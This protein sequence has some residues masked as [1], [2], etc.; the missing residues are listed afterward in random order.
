M[1]CHNIDWDGSV[2]TIVPEVNGIDRDDYDVDYFED[3]EWPDNQYYSPSVRARLPMDYDE[4]YLPDPFDEAVDALVEKYKSETP[5]AL[6]HYGTKRHSGRYPWGSGDNPYQHSSDFLARADA[7]KKSNFTM[8]DPDTGK[9]LTGEVAIARAFE[10]STTAFRARYAN[11][12]D[13]RRLREADI[14]QQMRRDGA[15]LREIATA[16]GYKNDSSVRVLLEDK[17]QAK[18]SKARATAEVLK[19]KLE[20]YNGEGYLEVGKGAEIYLGVSRTKLDQALTLLKDEGYEVWAG[21]VNQQTN[22]NQKT[23]TLVLCP[24]G[25]PKSAPYEYDKIHIVDDTISYDGGESFK[26]AWHYPES[27]DSKRLSI[28]YGDEGGTAKDGLV[29]IRRGVKDLSLGESNYAQ[30]RILV[31]DTHYIKG[32]AVYSNDLPDGVDV[33]FNTNKPSGTDVKDVLKSVD[34]NLKKDP[35]NPF[36]S[37]VK[38]HGGQ[39][40]YTDDDGKEKLG[41][42]N[43]TREEG[44]WDQWKD[45]LPSQFL[46]KQDIK[47]AKNQLDISIADAKAEFDDIMKVSNPVIRKNLLDAYALERDSD[48]EHLQ[49]AALP[50]QK[51]KVFLPVT[52]GLADNEVYCPSL[53]QGDRVAV[54]RFPHAGIFEIPILKV[55]NNVPQAEQMMGKTASDVI[56]ITAKTAAQLSGADFDGDAGLVIPIGGKVKIKATPYLKELEGYDPKAEYPIAVKD[57]GS[58]AK[59]PMSEKYKQKQMGVVSNLIT[60]MTVKNAKPEEVAEVTR[61]SMTVIDAVKHNLD[62]RQSA[63]DNHMDHWHETYQGSK[64]GGAS[65]ILSLAKSPARVDKRVGSPKIDPETGDLVWKTVKETYVDKKGKTQE[66]FTEVS[67]MSLVKDAHELSSGREIENVYA[68]FANAQKNLARKARLEILA[69]PHTKVNPGAR[70]EYADEVK[71]IDSKILKAKANAPREKQAQLLTASKVK[72]IKEDNPDLTKE[73]LKKLRTRT[74]TEMRNKVGARRVEA[75]LTEREW[76]AIQAGAISESKLQD[77]IRP[78]GIDRMRE[79]ATPRTNRVEMTEGKI[80][81]AK[82]MKEAGFTLAAIAERLGV[83][84]ATASKAIKS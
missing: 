27:L 51:Y 77:L 9:L 28:V 55:N 68:D 24:P 61:H 10:M 17:Q 82:A 26:P 32:M 70:A 37:L 50:R 18:R 59:K 35:N 53:K 23:N 80:A 7:L 8:V 49:A 3:D 69:T 64:T 75:D 21:S 74:L 25:T 5:D 84:S 22:M 30:V 4:D 31:D 78:V 63:I 66:R 65:T 47:L 73:E 43:K 81:Q 58:P 13:E 71:S 56:G 83:S 38:E 79:L 57:D 1:V 54:V 76:K 20:A 48:A 62:Y 16:L 34:K 2:T 14:A 46:A 67:K 19:E 44:D 15:S 39:N 42:V 33:R 36:G 29:E 6:Y 41:L 40:F 11:A 52:E 12:R 72:T 60:D 45:K